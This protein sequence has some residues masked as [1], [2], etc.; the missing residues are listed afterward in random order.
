V[1]KTS[2]VIALAALLPGIASAGAPTAYGQW[3]IDAGGTIATTTGV[4]GTA[5][6]P[7]GMTCSAT[8]VSDV[9]FLQTQMTDATGNTY[10]QTIIADAPTGTATTPPFSSEN[11]VKS[12]ATAGGIAAQQI[13]A[14]SDTNGAMKST[15]TLAVG[16]GFNNGTEN[17]VTMSQDLGD[18]TGEFHAGF[19][20]T[21]NSAGDASQT[22][23]NEQLKTA[24][25]D[26]A[27]S[28]VA[29]QDSTVNPTSGATT[30]AGQKIDIAMGIAL[31]PVGGA[32]TD[33][34][35]SLS[36]RGGTQLTAA[37]GPATINNP[38][39]TG[40][41]TSVTWAAGETADNVVIGQNVTDA[42]VFGYGD[43]SNDTTGV[44]ISDYSLASADGTSLYTV[45][46]TN[47]FS[48]NSPTGITVPTVTIP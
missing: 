7:T 2:L 19:G 27:T 5:G 29:T 11:Y 37:G 16:T 48:V 12:G 18:T 20:Y 44:E 15:T 28:F 42:G 43:I 14:S 10:F 46:G 45:T 24:A 1:K 33:Q 26:F 38:P 30:L 36:L 25:G 32:L 41:A 40:N 17:Q 39:G 31:N 9:G 13:I 35:F 3:T 8:P 34:T 23:L 4:G 6:C 22:T 47:P 21:K